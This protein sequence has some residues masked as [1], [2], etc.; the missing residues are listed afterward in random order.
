MEHCYVRRDVIPGSENLTSEANRMH[1]YS[2]FSYMIWPS[3]LSKLL[4]HGRAALNHKWGN[5]STTAWSTEV[6]RNIHSEI[7]WICT[8]VTPWKI[9]NDSYWYL[10]PAC[11]VSSQHGAAEGSVRRCSSGKSSRIML[12]WAIRVSIRAPVRDASNSRIAQHTH[13][14]TA[15]HGIY[16]CLSLVYFTLACSSPR[17]QTQ[18]ENLLYFYLGFVSF[19][20]LQFIHLFAT[21]Y[22]Y[23]YKTILIVIDTIV[24]SSSCW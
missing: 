12:H 16:E 21:L 18:E 20:W 11:V 3:E 13:T 4:Q 15:Y 22:R 10:K 17:G 6:Y 14:H 7:C 2:T 23:T 1:H 9:R 19:Y 8:R 5:I 24:T